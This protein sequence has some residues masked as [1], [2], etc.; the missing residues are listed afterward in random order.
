MP[1]AAHEPSRARRRFALPL[2]VLL[3]VVLAATAGARAITARAHYPTI[4]IMIVG[5]NGRVILPA[6]SITDAPATLKV[7]GHRCAVAAGTALAAL[8]DLA[9]AH[10]HLPLGLMAYEPCDTNP[11][12]AEGLFVETIDGIHRD[13][14][15]KG[16]YNGW[17]YKVGNRGATAGAGS[18]KGPFGNGRKLSTGQDVLWF[19][20]VYK[21]SLCQPTLGVSPA[22]T[23]AR[24]GG[25][26]DVKVD[27]YDESGKGTPADGATVTLGSQSATAGATGRVQITVPARAG[28]YLL[29]A[30]KRGLVTA[31][32]RTIVVTASGG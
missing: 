19:W 8:A 6:R 12:S 15:E 17:A 13:A 23:T 24:A 4:R 2:A 3:L 18:E 27:A 5:K 11:A 30:H 9:R 28:R 7:E 26:L 14:A 1:N 32:Q 10:V 20:C 16:T 21:G 31:F 22:H 29:S 25:K